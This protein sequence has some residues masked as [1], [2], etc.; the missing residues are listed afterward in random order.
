MDTTV[1]LNLHQIPHCFLLCVVRLAWVA[2]SWTDTLKRKR[3]S[4]HVYVYVGNS[5]GSLSE[6]VKLRVLACWWSEDRTQKCY[7][8]QNLENWKYYWQ[9]DWLV[10]GTRHSASKNWAA[11]YRLD[12]TPPLKASKVGASNTTTGSKFQNFTVL[13]KKELPYSRVWLVIIILKDKT[14][15]TFVF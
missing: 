4:C 3:E 6:D 8:K 7:H 10:Q 13:G 15:Y 9:N 5:A 1:G 11:A 12:A 14:M 2:R